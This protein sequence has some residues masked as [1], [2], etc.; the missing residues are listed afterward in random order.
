MA[1]TFESNFTRKVAMKVTDRFEANRVLSKNVNTQLVSGAFNPDSGTQV[2]VKRPT[3]YTVIDSADGD[4]ST[5]RSDIITGKATATVQ[6]YITV[7]VDYDEV[8]EALKL[9]SDN[10]R[11]FNDIANRMVIDLE[12]KFATFAMKNLGLNYGDPDQGVNSWAEVAGA[13]ALMQASGVPMNKKWCYF[14]NPHAQVALATEQRSLGVNPE[15]GS[16]NES[17]T[18]NKNFAGFD[19]KTATTLPTYTLPTTGDLVGA[20]TASVPDVTYN[21]AKD[22]MTQSIAL[23]GVG[24]FTG[25][26]PAGT[27]IQVTGVNRLNLSTRNAIVDATGASIVYSATVTADASFTTGAGTIIVTG[28]A[29]YEAAGAYNTV[30]RAIIENDVVTFMGTDATTFQPNLFWHPDALTLASV[31]IK[32]LHSTDTVATTSDGL[33][34]RISK[35]SD[36]AA[37]KQTVRFDLH[38]AF[39]V[40]NPFMGGHGY[41]VA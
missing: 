31:P 4:I 11:F 30:S 35:F 7:A 9:G 34:M 22:T 13:G 5:T 36:G 17:A 33:Q 16:A 19:V 40:M 38:P 20:V 10:D 28:P 1:N 37:N 2:D 26:I 21:T 3:D 24:T 39:G 29:I 12:L 25:T 32:K 8:D 18:I 23:D 15:S 41:G 14:L 27:T 6:N